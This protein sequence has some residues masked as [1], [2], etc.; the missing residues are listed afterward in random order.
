MITIIK[1]LAVLFFLTSV[2]FGWVIVDRTVS[3]DYAQNDIDRSYNLLS[4]MQRFQRVPCE[5]IDSIS[6]S[7]D[8]IIRKN[9][10]I[11]INDLEFTCN[12]YSQLLE[13]AYK[14]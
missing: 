7:S 14:P 1:T 6:T 2:F 10:Y 3:L 12:E 8:A 11:H 13:S 9:G 5:M 4:T